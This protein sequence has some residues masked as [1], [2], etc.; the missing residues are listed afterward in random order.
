L[1]E[2]RLQRWINDGDD[3]LSWFYSFARLQSWMSDGDDG[4]MWFFSYGGTAD[5][6]DESESA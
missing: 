4:P 6:A 3:G 2:V 5:D 1:S